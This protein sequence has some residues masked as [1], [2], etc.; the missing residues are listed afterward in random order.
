MS[1]RDARGPW[2]AALAVGLLAT[3]LRMS[4]E[5]PLTVGGFEIKVALDAAQ[6]LVE[7]AAGTELTK[8]VAQLFAVKKPG[9]V[10]AI[11]FLDDCPRTLAAAG[12]TTRIRDKGG[13][14]E[15]TFKKRY[16][17]KPD[18]DAALEKARNDGFTNQP[19]QK[20]EVDVVGDRKTLSLSI[21]EPLP[22]PP[23]PDAF[24][25]TATAKA[26]ERLSAPLL[27]ALKAAQVYGPIPAK[28]W[29]GT[30][31]GTG[32]EVEIEAWKLGA[33]HVVELSSK[34]SDAAGAEKLRRRLGELVEAKHLGS[35]KEV[36]KTEA[37]LA[38]FPPTGCP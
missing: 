13:E 28:R 7:G 10:M 36:L 18:L 23:P 1:L 29:K 21:D 32:E 11:H 33:G 2:L 26:P 31:P 8:D 17:A 14:W 6:T 15:L 5:S 3:S 12:W 20:V 19:G 4:A 25:A 16:P 30:L 34:T 37:A 35:T 9:K 27:A 24:V 38:A 22:P